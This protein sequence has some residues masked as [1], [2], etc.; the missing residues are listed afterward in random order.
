MNF[1]DIAFA[2][3]L[4]NNLLFFHFLGLGE[5]LS[6]GGTKNV[7]QRTLTLG[8]LLVFSASAYW[9]ADFYLLQPFHLEFLRT[10]LTLGLLWLT[11][12][13]WSLLVRSRPGMGPQARELIVHSFLVGAVLLVGSTSPGLA[14][15]IVA[16]LAVTLGYG[17][18]LILL[19]AVS[20][21]LSRESIPVFMHGLPLQLVTLGMVWLIL[22]G[23]GFAFAGKAA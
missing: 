5:I 21:R 1:L 23:L 13:S 2:S 3:L 15:V 16:S 14:E 22:Q 8:L 20:H 18:A 6:E 7:V 9:V 19:W 4:A 17:G 12:S 11:V 10:V